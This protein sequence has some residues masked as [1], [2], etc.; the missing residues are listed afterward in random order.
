MSV[1]GA[2]PPLKV[3][4]HGGP[5]LHHRLALLQHVV[6]HVRGLD[7]DVAVRGVLLVRERA[8]DLATLE[9]AVQVAAMRDARAAAIARQPLQDVGPRQRERIGRLPVGRK[10]LDVRR[11]RVPGDVNLLRR[12]HGH[13]AH[14]DAHLAGGG[15]GA[16]GHGR[17]LGLHRSRRPG[18][19][20]GDGT[21]KGGGHDEHG[22]QDAKAEPREADGSGSAGGHGALLVFVGVE[23]CREQRHGPATIVRET[24]PGVDA[25]HL[26]PTSRSPQEAGANPRQDRHAMLVGAVGFEPTSSCSQSTCA[27]VAPRPDRFRAQEAH[28]LRRSYAF[29]WPPPLAA[30]ACHPSQRP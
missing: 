6:R 18:R 5:D 19:T 29:D 14:R 28:M 23:M 3:E 13:G 4:I 9:E 20:A 26:S 25:G 12:G 17:C 30:D 27:T 8:L 21:T 22:Q 7:A 2:A 11:A 10:G 16:S 1:P 15:P 24:R